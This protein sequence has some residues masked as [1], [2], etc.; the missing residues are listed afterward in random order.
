MLW[1]SR[2]LTAIIALFFGFDGVTKLMNIQAVKD[3][4]IQLGYPVGQS[5]LLGTMLLASLAL[6][7]IPRTAVLG[8]ILLT[9]YL[10]GAVASQIR[11]GSPVL[12]HSLFPVYFGVMVWGALYL[13]DA[14]LRA[15]IPFQGTEG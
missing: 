11:V 12:T 3:G 2:I 9:G 14:R 1:T 4:M 10:G 7:L 6:Y 5:P 13:R 15:L 8:A